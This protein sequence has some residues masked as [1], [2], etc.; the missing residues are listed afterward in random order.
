M[1]QSQSTKNTKNIK[2]KIFEENIPEGK[3][4]FPPIQNDLPKSNPTQQTAGNPTEVSNK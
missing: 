2:V 1:Q 4:V 3:S